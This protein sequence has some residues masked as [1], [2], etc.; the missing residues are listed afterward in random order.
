MRRILIAAAFACAL[1]L[2]RPAIAEISSID[3]TADNIAFYENEWIVTGDGNVRVTL[4]DGTT[5]TGRT[6]SMDLKLNRFLVAGAVALQ[7]PKEYY[8]GAAFSE[9][10]D[11]RRGYFIPVI[12]QP[13][14]WTFLD[15]NYAAP[16][17]GREMP[18]DAFDFKDT[19]EHPYILARKARIVPKTGVAFSPASVF[20]L[21]AY[22][23][24]PYWY[25]NF[26]S[27]PNF[28][29][30]SLHGATA[31][32][33]YPFDGNKNETSVVHIRYD[34]TDKLYYGLEEHIVGQRSYAIASIEP[35]D[36]PQKQYN[37]LAS[38]KIGN[39]F[40]LQTFDQIN[41]FQQGF[42]QPLS[43]SGFENLQ[44]TY[45]LTNS[46][47]QL[48][49]NQYQDSLLAQPS[50]IDPN[51][52]LPYYGDPSHPWYPNHPSNAQLSWIGADRRVGRSPFFFRLRSGI[53]SAHDS[54]GLGTFFT[55]PYTSLWQHFLGFTAW[56]SSFKLGGASVPTDRAFALQAT[57]DRQRTY[58]DFPRWQEQ[59][60][61]NAVLSRGFGR[62]G[63]AY[64]AYSVG[65]TGDFLGGLQDVFYPPT[66]VYDV[67]TGQVYAS[68]QSFQGF[69]TTHALTGALTYTPTPYFSFTV[70][71]ERH[72]D[73]PEPIP[74]FTG[75][76]P[77]VLTARTHF[78]LTPLIGVDVARSY[79][80]DWA[81]MVWS[82]TFQVQIGP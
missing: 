10:L 8:T 15:E 80:F 6:F 75:Q 48:T 51:T 68:W 22:V 25:Q 1:A 30:N 21:G 63:S 82:P 76:P 2:P 54:F 49:A 45:A 40:Q 71:A 70:Q 19:P 57:Y 13:D 36:H 55:T 81:R 39:R 20:A 17:K 32:F 52:G 12:D 3:V 56:T 67:Y 58:V 35:I 69:A 62:K 31:D 34:T 74:Y 60:S 38:Q 14:R 64:I 29:Q 77:Y 43:A 28:A 5:V 9:F 26:S 53:L 33:G 79:Y 65:Q 27:N 72:K 24:T 46:Y 4:S 37:L 61:G 50:A 7:T 47:L 16:A 78:R 42:S 66:S 73:F 59:Q 11:Y 44:F 18:G 41:A 23:P